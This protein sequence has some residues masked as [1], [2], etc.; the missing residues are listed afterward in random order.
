MIIPSSYCLCTTVSEKALAALLE[1]SGQGKYRDNHPWLVALD[2]LDAARAAAQ[3]LPVLFATGQPSRF[4]HWGFVEELM[5][6][7]LHRA[8]WETVLTFTPLQPV[9]PIWTELDSVLLKPTAE[10]LERETREGIHQHRY[11]VTEGEIH[12]YAICETP[13]FIGRD[14]P[15]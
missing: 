11:P 3:R 9:N 12:P 6:V 10:Q 1:S 2:M 4:S 15:G 13:A 8:T 7:E 5:V 14:A